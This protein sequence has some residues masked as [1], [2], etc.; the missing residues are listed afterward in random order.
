MTE[1][2]EQLASIRNTLMKIQRRGLLVE[3]G[4]ATAV[5]GTEIMQLADKI[6]EELI[7]IFNRPTRED[8]RAVVAQTALDRDGHLG[9]VEQS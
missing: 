1:L 4:E 5:D 2:T 8:V 6:N 3:R 7:A 9:A